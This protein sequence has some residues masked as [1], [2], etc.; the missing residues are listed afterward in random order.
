MH[1]GLL[2]LTDTRKINLGHAWE[3]GNRT[4]VVSAMSQLAVM[5]KLGDDFPT[6]GDRLRSFIEQGGYIKDL[7][8]DSIDALHETDSQSSDLIDPQDKCWSALPTDAFVEILREFANPQANSREVAQFIIATMRHAK[9]GVAT[10]PHE[11]SFLMAALLEEASELVLPTDASALAGINIAKP[12]QKLIVQMKNQPVATVLH[13]LYFSMGNKIDLIFVPPNIDF[14]FAS[15]LP[16][17]LIPEFGGKVGREFDRQLPDQLQGP[18]RLTSD[19][20]ALAA[21]I[22]E[23]AGM[24]VALVPGS[25]LFRGGRSRQFRKWLVQEVGLTTVI[26]LPQGLLEGTTLSSAIL[27]IDPENVGVASPDHVLMLSA[28]SKEYLSEIYRGRYR[29]RG[30]QKLRDEVKGALVTSPEHFVDKSMLADNDYV[31]QRS[32]YSARE[33]S[34]LEEVLRGKPVVTLGAVVDVHS[35]LSVKASDSQKGTKYS[36]VRISDF[37]IDGTVSNGSKEILVGSSQIGR[38]DRQVLKSGDV[39]LG[40]KGSIGKC[41]VVAQDAQSN[42]MAS[43][44][45]V[46]LRP[47]KEGSTIHPIVLL[48]YLSLPEVRKYLESLSGGTTISFLRKKDLVDIPIP[49]LTHEQQQHIVAVHQ[50]ILNA[51]DES[52]RQMEKAA[53]LS[54]DAFSDFVHT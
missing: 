21:V 17:F 24:V 43:Q 13:R 50:H 4:A 3:S 18:G 12:N 42:L 34:G 15:A 54:D 32:R 45:M 16:V 31:L 29:L 38:L 27:L 46:I 7:L 41:A 22:S 35:P 20:A 52:Q 6:F 39:L 19:E 53:R 2:D 25:F 30:W 51:L 49:I 10:T 8:V 14:G 28:D 1:L 37:E 26:T 47:K 33:D 5:V 44:T 36:E 48:R 23:G 9:I 40:T 11:I